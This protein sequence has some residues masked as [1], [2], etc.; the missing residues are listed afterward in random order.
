MQ[1]YNEKET[2]QINDSIKRL[3]AQKDRAI[4]SYRDTEQAK[5]QAVADNKAQAQAQGEWLVAKIQHQHKLEDEAKERT[6]ERANAESET[7]K[8]I[9]EQKTQDARSRA[10]ATEN[11]ELQKAEAW[12]SAAINSAQEVSD[13]TFSI[14]QNGMQ[15]EISAINSSLRPS[16]G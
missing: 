6:L 15:K 3:E 1:D 10:I 8:A 12:K 11:L 16:T 2:E 7:L 14:L 9:E 5:A 4:K 13:A